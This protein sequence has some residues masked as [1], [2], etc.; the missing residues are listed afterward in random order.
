[1]N[2]GQLLSDSIVYRGIPPFLLLTVL[3]LLLGN[4]VRTEIQAAGERWLPLMFWTVLALFGGA[5]LVYL[6]FPNFI[7]HFEASIAGQGQVLRSGND[8]YP[9]PDPYPYH[10]TQYGPLLA[11]IQLVFGSLGLPVIVAAKIPGYLAFIGAITC[12]LA[13][14]KSWSAR[15]YLLYLLPFLQWAAWDRAEPFLLL[16]VSGTLLLCSRWSQALLMPLALGL[17]AGLASALKLHGAVYVV[18]ACTA[19][20]AVISGRSILLFMIGGL[21]AFLASYAPSTISIG[22]FT[23]YLQVAKAHGLNGYL[24]GHNIAYLL[25]LLA[26]FFPYR[27]ELSKRIYL[28][29]TL[30]FL[31]T[32]IAAKPGAGS[33]H[34]FPFIPINA[35]L[36]QQLLTK[37]TLQGKSAPWILTPVYSALMAQTVVGLYVMANTMATYWTLFS[38]AKFEAQAASRNYPGIVMGATDLSAHMFT[39]LRVV[40]PGTQIDYPALMDLRFAGVGDAG[41][42]QHLKS[43][44]IRFLLMPNVGQ[45]FSLPNAGYDYQPVFSDET[46]AQ[47]R[48]KYSKIEEGR[49]FSM[50]ECTPG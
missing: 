18:A 16:A 37:S 27:R 12:C 29:M 35:F 21:V 39:S 40:M 2:W 1:M 8:L 19:A 46:R 13:L 10:G 25:F 34:L 23:Q 4:P 15:G 17:L 44:R 33:H 6:A 31:V 20:L 24:W 48:A 7:D 22:A 50:Y 28:I 5:L 47:F 49:Y 42:A 14:L 32:I 9:F 11:L 38:G 30:E 45:P 3:F 36:F 41:L 26:P 43:C